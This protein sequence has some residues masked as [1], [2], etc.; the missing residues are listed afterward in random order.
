M[1]PACAQ[2]PASTG[3]PCREFFFLLRNFW[4]F[5]PRVPGTQEEKENE[6]TEEKD[7]REREGEEGV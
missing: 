6:E 3:S 1:M 2:R 4:A 5:R 7:K